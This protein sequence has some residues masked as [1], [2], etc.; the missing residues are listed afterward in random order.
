M[1]LI[2]T[3]TLDASQYGILLKRIWTGFARSQDTDFE[4]TLANLFSS[5]M[6]GVL[7]LGVVIPILLTKTEVLDS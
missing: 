6:A 2:N 3:V 5:C 1:I 4:R 7:G